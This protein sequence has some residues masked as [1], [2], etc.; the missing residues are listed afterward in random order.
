ML[1]MEDDEMED[2]EEYKQL[3]AQ[4]DEIS[5]KI[6]ELEAEDTAHTDTAE[7]V[8]ELRDQLVAATAAN[9]GGKAIGFP[10]IF[11]T[12][13]LNFAGCAVARKIPNS[14]GCSSRLSAR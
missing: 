2:D 13:S 14:P 12:C 9:A 11:S 8:A 5:D 1:M 6:A 7:D 4:A 10:R 3:S